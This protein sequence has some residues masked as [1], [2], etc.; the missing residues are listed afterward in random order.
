MKYYT[1]ILS[2]FFV[3]KLEIQNPTNLNS[4]KMRSDN[5][6]NCI[7]I[8]AT[9]D[10]INDLYLNANALLLIEKIDLRIIL[11][12]LK[13]FNV[14]STKLN[15]IY[16]ILVNGIINDDN[17]ED[18]MLKLMDL[19]VDT[20]VNILQFLDMKSIFNF[21]LTSRECCYIARIPQCLR[22]IYCKVNR[23]PPETS[24]SRYKQINRLKI[25]CDFSVIDTKFIDIVCKNVKYLGIRNR[26]FEWLT[27]F[28][29]LKSVRQFSSNTYLEYM[30]P[31]AMNIETVIHNIQ[32]LSLAKFEMYMY[33]S[34]NEFGETL[35]PMKSNLKLLIITKEKPRNDNSILFSHIMLRF[36]QQT[37]LCL[38]MNISN[39][40]QI[41]LKLKEKNTV[42]NL[43]KLEGLYTITNWDI[44]I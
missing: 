16:K 23:F 26:L 39:L 38:D 17:N 43:T 15:E 18:E 1:Y 28:P 44:N 10:R 3:W 5:I 24:Y 7:K 11:K 27:L 21:E 35:N 29:N 19:H 41:G 33:Q 22:Y 34:I 6:G 14:S 8:S 13:Y 37:L 20:L 9:L 25:W 4:N 36:G 42:I 2:F 12:N 32:I 31:L 40:T 30:N